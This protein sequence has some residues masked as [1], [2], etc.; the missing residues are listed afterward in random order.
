MND[1]N[2]FGDGPLASEA[3]R[4]FGGGA[5]GAR[6]V[7]S[8]GGDNPFAR[9]SDATEPLATT[10]HDVNIADDPPAAVAPPSIDPATSDPSASHSTNAT[11]PLTSSSSSSS[12]A[13]RDMGPLTPPAPAPSANATADSN[14]ATNVPAMGVSYGDL[15]AP[16]PS[17]ADS[18]MYSAAPFASST[19]GGRGAA[20]EI[21]PAAAATARGASNAMAHTTYGGYGGGSAGGSSDGGSMNADPFAPGAAR[22][23]GADVAPTRPLA[24]RTPRAYTSSVEGVLDVTVSDPKTSG[25]GGMW[26][27]VVM[28]KVHVRTDLPSYASKDVVTWRRFRDFVGLADRLAESHRGFFVP[29]RPEKTLVNS[30][31][32]KFVN[33]RMTQLQSYLAKLCSHPTLRH[34]SELRL[35]LTAHDLEVNPTWTGFKTNPSA[36]DV[37]L[38]G[39]PGSPSAIGTMAMMGGGIENNANHP[40]VMHPAG[41]PSGSGGGGRKIGRFFKELRQTV[42]QSSAVASVGATFGIETHKPKVTEEDLDFIAERDRVARLEQELSIAS[43][44][45]ERVLMQEEKYGDALGELGLECMKLAK[46]EET[47]AHK[48]GEGVVAGERGLETGLM[49][50][51]IGNATVRVSRLTRAATTQLAHA[52]DPMHDYLGMMPAVRKA[53]GDRAETLLTLQTMLSDIEAKSAKLSKLELDVAK[54]SK[55]AHLRYELEAL[56][57]ASVGVKAEYE[58]IKERH[59]EEFKRLETARTDTFKNMWLAFA[60]VQVLNAERASQVWKAAAEELGASPEE[61]TS[62][63]ASVAAEGSPSGAGGGVGGSAGGGSTP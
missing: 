42:V 39:G 25:G 28:Y 6:L 58:N 45:A 24:V 38:S 40:H 41:A 56:R 34:A 33:D 61:W 55:A 27:R 18:M 50:R 7:E 54:T 52:L 12:A 26:K 16:P 31:E 36:A 14:A 51:K 43:Q 17:Y 23:G 57:S 62:M 13:A 37:V 49:A 46:V 21:F 44:K 10:L 60:R 11:N 35:F 19:T 8:F 48:L 32:E 29:P 63:A 9:A 4:D 47:E 53:T 30:T 1:E 3:G 2:P 5:A 22:F 20:S 59:A 15:L